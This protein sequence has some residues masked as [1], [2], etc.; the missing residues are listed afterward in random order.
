[1][2][3][4]WRLVVLVVGVYVA[5]VVGRPLGVAVLSPFYRPVIGDTP[6]LGWFVGFFVTYAVVAW[7]VGL[8]PAMLGAGR[9]RD[10]STTV[11]KRRTIGYFGRGLVALI[12]L[13][14]LAV[15]TKIIAGVLSVFIPGLFDPPP[16][17][18]SG[19]MTAADVFGVVRLLLFLTLWIGVAVWLV[20][21]LSRPLKILI[22]RKSRDFRRNLRFMSAGYGGSAAFAGLLDEWANPYEPGCL[23]LGYSLYDPGWRVGVR[24]DRHVLAMAGTGAGKGRTCVIP[25]LMEWPHS[26]LVIDPKG[27]NA[28]VTAARR[29][30]GGGNVPKSEAMGQK[31]YC[32]NP[33]DVNADQE[34][35]PRPSRFNCGFR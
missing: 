14:G 33:F 10:S 34:G 5:W 1:M 35:M 18:A 26:A 27:T 16:A 31:V 15:V 29:G 22:G 4:L 9:G 28:A 25:N 7:L 24:D 32:I 12:P 30:A 8:V 21:R 6:F 11:F 17:H 19:S 13:V 20:H 2:E 3:K 23:L